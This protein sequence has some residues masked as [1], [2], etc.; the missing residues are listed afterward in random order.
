MEKT[1]QERE[2][3][4]AGWKDCGW[5]ARGVKPGRRNKLEAER[6]R[7]AGEESTRN[8]SLFENAVMR[9]YHVC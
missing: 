6:G 9:Q 2:G 8:V 7:E 4:V 1:P 3:R 5:D